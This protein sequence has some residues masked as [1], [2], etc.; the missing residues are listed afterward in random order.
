MPSAPAA[1]MKRVSAK[2]RLTHV[3]ISQVPHTRCLTPCRM[4]TCLSSRHSMS[5]PYPKISRH[6]KKATRARQLADSDDSAPCAGP[7]TWRRC[8]LSSRKGNGFS[9]NPKDAVENQWCQADAAGGRPSL[10]LSL[11]FSLMVGRGRWHWCLEG[12]A[13]L[14]SSLTLPLVPP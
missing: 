4:S 10:C 7:S 11:S 3:S 14:Q 9:S 5:A 1:K 6:L 8:S 12:V 2:E 13:V